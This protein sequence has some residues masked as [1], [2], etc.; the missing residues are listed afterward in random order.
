MISYYLSF[1]LNNLRNEHMN[2]AYI[3]AQQ[4]LLGIG[5]YSNRLYKRL[6]PSRKI[7]FDRT[8]RAKL[9]RSAINLGIGT[10][11]GTVDK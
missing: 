6:L 7:G 1:N 9:S 3:Y 8:R 11:I 10:S 4:T 2:E 5:F